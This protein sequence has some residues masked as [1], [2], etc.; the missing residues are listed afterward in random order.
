L[1][2]NPRL[3]HRLEPF[4]PQELLLPTIEAVIRIF[5]RLGNRRNRSK[6]RLKFLIAD[7]GVEAFRELV[8]EERA[9]L[10]MLNA[11][12]YPVFSSEHIGRTAAPQPRPLLKNGSSQLRSEPYGFALWHDT[13]VV[14]Q[15]QPGFSA[16]FIT[17]P[18]GDLTA[19]QFRELA[20]IARHFAGGEAVTTATQNLTLRWVPEDALPDLYLAL[21]AIG[22][23]G[24]GVN[25]PPNVVGCPGADTCNVALTTSHR[26][27]LE[28]NRRLSAQPDFFL[29]D[30]MEGIDI[31][32][33]GCPNSCGHHHIA[34]IGLHG[35]V[36]R[37]NGRQVPHYRLLLGGRI[38]ENGAAFG[39]PVAA[40][41]AR[42]VP[43][44]VERILTLYRLGRQPGELFFDW[45]DLVGIPFFKD[46]LKEFQILP[47]PEEDPQVYQDWGQDTAY[48]LQVGEAECA[49]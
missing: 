46:A 37:V 49:A 15:K 41:P 33:S 38:G 22:L 26:L 8:L 29:D 19:S 24:S 30:S 47:A 13:N 28:L 14:R 21:Q 18:G 12:P 1:G 7:I 23:S 20:V 25:R 17:V 39:V 11:T 42:N 4:T 43:A 32:V 5:D 34:A 40:V 35:S 9:V 27:A 16:A 6:A 31:K 10:P 3:A 48:S 45:I 36:R 2:A 44:A